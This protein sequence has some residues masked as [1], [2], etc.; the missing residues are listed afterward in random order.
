M[1]V[2][3]EIYVPENAE[4]VLL[5]EGIEISDAWKEKFN[6]YK[7]TLKHVREQT[8][9]IDRYKKKIWRM[10]Q[11]EIGLK[12]EI[13]VLKNKIELLEKS[14]ATLTNEKQQLL[15]GKAAERRA[16]LRE[17]SEIVTLKNMISK[18]NREIIGLE[19]RI[20]E[21]ART[22]A[23]QTMKN[24]SESTT[25]NG[26]IVNEQVSSDSTKEANPVESTSIDSTI[27]GNSVQELELFISLVRAI[28]ACKTRTDALAILDGEQSYCFHCGRSFRD[29]AE[30][31]LCDSCSYCVIIANLMKEREKPK[32]GSKEM[33][34]SDFFVFLFVLITIGLAIFVYNWSEEVASLFV[35]LRTH[36]EGFFYSV[37]F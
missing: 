25:E 7:M 32:K 5:K 23:S 31:G 24:V 10:K 34:L 29:C 4:D 20:A 26:T 14:I 6:Q 16:D 37:C 36:I 22:M 18:K 1:D 27:C 12:S 9:D 13:N 19:R 2:G 30:D 3:D 35:S 28:S 11:R 17:E 33:E 15:D 21:M 8:S